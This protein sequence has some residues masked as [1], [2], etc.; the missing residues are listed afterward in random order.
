MT[1]LS[2]IS[3]RPFTAADAEECF[4]IR[5][6]AFLQEFYDEQDP[7]VIVAGINAYLPSD[8]IRMSE[9]SHA[10]VA[11]DEDRV[12]GF[13][14]LKI[15]DD[16][17]AELILLYLTSGYKGKGIGSLLINHMESWLGENHPGVDRIE[18]DTIVPRYNKKFYEKM[19]YA[20]DGESELQYPGMT[21]KAVRM[22]K[23]LRSENI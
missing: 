19:G 23:K 18:L 6:E 5:T 11:T 12:I 8:Y 16:A 10:C 15:I 22:A 3:I 2:K 1:E 17:T 9:T 13:F 14:I 20:E 4:S 21:V 7:T